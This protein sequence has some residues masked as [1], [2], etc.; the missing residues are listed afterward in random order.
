MRKLL[1]IALLTNILYAESFNSLERSIIIEKTL[2]FLLKD[3]KELRNDVN[4]L[5]EEN[6]KLTQRV[7][8][9]DGDTTKVN[10]IISKIIDIEKDVKV[11][12]ILDDYTPT[13]SQTDTTS[14]II[15][16]YLKDDTIKATS[17]N[18]IWMKTSNNSYIKINS[19]ELANKKS[20]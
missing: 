2:N 1:Y 7:K 4:L 8:L 17:H 16:L 12:K 6:R 13:Y 18:T 19:I 9:L 15:N 14:K 10:T 5:K 11:Y 20:E 3:F